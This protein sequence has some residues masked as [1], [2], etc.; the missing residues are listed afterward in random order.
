MSWRQHLDFSQAFPPPRSEALPCAKLLA[1][2]AT[3]GHSCGPGLAWANTQG[4]APALMKCVPSRVSTALE[5][6]EEAGLVAWDSGTQAQVPCSTPRAIR[7]R[8]TASKASVLHQLTRLG[9][10]WATRDGTGHHHGA[11]PQ[12]WDLAGIGQVR[13]QSRR[14]ITWRRSQETSSYALDFSFVNMVQWQ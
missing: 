6:D 1:V 5:L 11:S 9:S 7:D 2:L 14:L 10:D 4:K 8:L 12:N 3:E 13:A